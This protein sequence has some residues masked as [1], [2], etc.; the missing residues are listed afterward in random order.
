MSA[1]SSTQPATS[2]SPADGAS[3]GATVAAPTLL[4]TTLHQYLN[5][6]GDPE[7]RHR[8]LSTRRAAASVLA[9][10]PRQQ[11]S[12][13]A[14]DEARAL[15]RDVVAS[16]LHDLPLESVDAA[17]ADQL[18]ALGWTGLLGAMLLAPAWQWKAAPALGDVP[19]WLWS[20]YTAWLFA[21][22]LGFTAP[23]QAD[24]FAAHVLRRAQELWGWVQ[25]NR[26]SA[27][28]R[29]AL[30]A[31]VSTA[32][33]ITLYFHAGSLRAHAE[34]RGRLLT[35][36][37]K[38]PDHG[39][40]PLALAR[41]GR[42]LRVGFL[43]RHFGS[44]TETYTT[45]PAFEQLDPARFEVQLFALKANPGPL[46]DYIRTR[47]AG[48]HLLPDD[49]DGQLSQLQAAGLDVLVFGTN[50]TAVFNEVTRLALHRLAPLQVINNSSCITSGLPEAD[51]YVSGSAT[52]APGAE[53][54]FS[55]RL[56]LL[57][58]PAHAFNYQADAAAPSVAPT[59][60]SLG[61]PEDAV[62]FV[63]AANYFKVIPE[64]QAAWARLLAAVP[65]SYLLLHPFNPN[66]SSSYPIKRFCAEFDRVLAAA[67]VAGSRLIVST[68]R[69]PSRTDV[70]ELL[71]VGDLYLDS[72][73]FSGV[74][75]LV[76]PLEAGLPTVAW[77]GD[78]FRSRM[79]SALLRELGLPGLIATNAEEYH[80]IALRLA[81]GTEERRALSSRITG[82][83][84]NVPVFLDTQAAS[85][86]FGDLLETAFD[87]MAALGPELFRSTRTP[88]AAGGSADP[89]QSLQSARLD[90]S[91]G[92]ASS[93]AQHAR[94][95]LRRRPNHP[96]AR[97][98]LGQAQLL[99]GNASLAVDYLLGAVQHLHADAGVWYDL[100]RAFRQ[101]GRMPQAIQAL[102]RSLELDANRL[103]SWL[104]LVEVARP[105]GADDLVQQATDIARQLAPADPRVLA[106]P[107][108]VAP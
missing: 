53:A 56:G 42:R 6:P 5:E 30:S 77:E 74:N 3:P 29:A 71:R 76:D 34:V 44:Q 80:T 54:Q 89:G 47:A 72:Y 39:I 7:T 63:S 70:R 82:T 15:I 97:H 102:Q 104:M 13:P 43:N 103:E 22:P 41:E 59:R 8:L 79:A 33:C 83:M 65:N 24:Q 31:Y 12:G 87:E 86:A 52:E 100:A 45:L 32:S 60:A 64:M 35:A 46:E 96:E 68:N 2:E 1:S 9:A 26:G 101:Q 78:S 49:V 95:I 27:A 85:D 36:A 55:E 73:P 58:G 4:R 17:L 106:L 88:L 18:A 51:L 48:F 20:D 28:V 38:R 91:L 92:L 98:V 99:L 107:A 14:V 21:T 94:D 57:P 40:P 69:F 23:G 11:K 10:L 84:Q 67:G 75:S 19:E 108:A 61:L 62:V 90:L 93:A 25:R 37:Q 50:V 16:G 81:T 105:M 66:W